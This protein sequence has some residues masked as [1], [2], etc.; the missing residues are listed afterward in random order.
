MIDLLCMLLHQGLRSCVN[1][2]WLSV[3]ENKLESLEGI[4]GLTKLTVSTSGFYFV[5]FY[6]YFKL[7]IIYSFVCSLFS[8]GLVNSKFSGNLN[9]VCVVNSF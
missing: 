3:V 7:L 8:S 5:T 2:K 1:L 9:G 4:Q 6:F